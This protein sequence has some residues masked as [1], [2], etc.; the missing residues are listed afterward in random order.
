MNQAIPQNLQPILW[1]AKVSSFDL[2][3]DKVYIIHQI[4]AY[5]DLQ[6]IKWLF[7]TYDKKTIKDVFIKHPQRIYTPQG[8]NFIKTIILK[9]EKMPLNKDRYISN[10]YTKESQKV[11]K[12][13][14]NI[15]SKNSTQP[16]MSF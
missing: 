3:R 6:K 13:V 11:T 2:K 7:D 16:D 10:L 9:L 1:S 4:L 12:L 15:F 14:I 8:F 5:G